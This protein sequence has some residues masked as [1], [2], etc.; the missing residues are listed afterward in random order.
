MDTLEPCPLP[1]GAVYPSVTHLWLAS[2]GSN[3]TSLA[4]AFPNLTHLTVNTLLGSVRPYQRHLQLAS[5][6]RGC[7]HLRALATLE[8]LDAVPAAAK[9]A[10]KELTVALWDDR[11][12]VGM[13]NAGFEQVT[14]HATGS[15]RAWVPQRWTV[16]GKRRAAVEAMQRGPGF[17]RRAEEAGCELHFR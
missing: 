1:R 8:G 16:L 3:P 7:S 4:P 2:A 12:W 6:G 15:G 5:L 10:V 9:L 14:E 13:M 17:L 11:E